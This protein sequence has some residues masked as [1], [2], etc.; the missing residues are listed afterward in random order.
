M[1]DIDFRI[2]WLIYQVVAGVAMA[3]IAYRIWIFCNKIEAVLDKMAVS[4]VI[5]NIDK[6]EPQS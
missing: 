5:P 3:L 4:K 2:C 6:S 1:R